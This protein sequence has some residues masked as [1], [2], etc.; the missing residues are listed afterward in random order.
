MRRLAPRRVRVRL[1]LL[2]TLLFLCGGI[3]LLGLTFALVSNSLRTGSETAVPKRPSAALIRECK[4]PQ[5]VHVGLNGKKE[6]TPLTAQCKKAFS[7]GAIQATSDQR[8]HT[9]HEL[10]VYALLGLGLLTIAS[11][12]LGWVV[13]GRV[14]RPVREITEAARRASDRHLGE[15][16]NL[17]G[18]E[19]ELKELADTFDAMLDRLDLA[20]AAQRQFVANASH[21]LRTPLTSMRTAIDV[22]L[23]KP[24]RTAAQLEAM[25]EKVRRS[26]DRDERIIDALLT[27]AVSN[28]GLDTRE[29]LDLATSAEDALDGV[30][31]AAAT[32]GLVIEADLHPSEVSGSRIL[33]D[34]LVGNLVQNAVVHNVPD[35]WVRV[36]TGST[37]GHAFLEVTNTG[38]V[39]PAD[40]LP[41]LFEPFR[42]VEARTAFGGVGLGLSIVESVAHAHDGVVDACPHQG[43]GL[44]VTLT[45][46]VRRESDL[47][48]T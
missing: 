19:D 45:V 15:R 31:E 12:G 47:M 32:A 7:A 2:Y 33:L 36:R 48:T 43:G 10:E 35:G 17:S 41:Q 13:A 1:T 46:P 42:R 39:I 37:N 28:Q 38:P 44:V 27:L 16:L 18:P 4:T 6:P 24:N 21:E 23:A 5:P 11:A 40:D 34:R 26:I 8:G 9:M 3:A 25:A 14:L 30:R 29:P 20:F 22:V